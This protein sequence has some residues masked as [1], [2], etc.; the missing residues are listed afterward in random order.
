MQPPSQR[1]L[2]PV[3]NAASGSHP[4]Y[5]ASAFGRCE[6]EH[7]AI[8]L[9]HPWRLSPILQW[10]NYMSQITHKQFD[11]HRLLIIG[12]NGLSARIQMLFNRTHNSATLNDARRL[13]VDH[14]LNLLRNG[15]MA[16]DAGQN[17]VADRQAHRLESQGLANNVRER[18]R[19]PLLGDAV[20]VSSRAR[21]VAIHVD[22]IGRIAHH[23]FVPRLFPKV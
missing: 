12:S 1:M 17:S 7:G 5:G 10:S 14:S 4:V 3:M 23:P 11:L 21:P 19:A 20:W 6:V 2:V 13:V 9:P 16:L 8:A 22:G 18:V 15:R